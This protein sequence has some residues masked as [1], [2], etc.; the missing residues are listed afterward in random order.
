M[1]GGQWF[2]NA[3]GKK[4][5]WI[6][7]KKKKKASRERKGLERKDFL[8]RKTQ[9]LQGEAEGEKEA[10]QHKADHSLA[11]RFV[12]YEIVH[13]LSSK[14]WK[15]IEKYLHSRDRWERFSIL[16][17]RQWHAGGEM[18]SLIGN[19]LDEVHALCGA[20]KWTRGRLIRPQNQHSA[21]STGSGGYSF[22][23]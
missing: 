20:F 18:G 5:S 22:V 14:L 15:L 9:R 12:T 6:T 2:Q 7:E 16:C 13:G 19:M 1:S 23:G 3:W 17:A 11:L 10:E 21:E 4:C 8:I